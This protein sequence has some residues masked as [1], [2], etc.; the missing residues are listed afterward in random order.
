MILSWYITSSYQAFALHFR[1]WQDCGALKEGHL[2]D[3]KHRKQDSYW[4][5]QQTHLISLLER[6]LTEY[7]I[8]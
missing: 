7:L 8:I 5:T 3:P 4:E 6:T 1:I 2:N